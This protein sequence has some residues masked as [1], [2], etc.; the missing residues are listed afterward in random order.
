MELFVVLKALFETSSPKWIRRVD[1][2]VSPF[3]INRFLALDKR[4]V[5]TAQ[6][7]D[8]YTFTLSTSQWLYLAW[9]TL[10]RLENAPFF[11]Y[12]KKKTVVDDEPLL[13]AA[14]E[15]LGVKGNDKF[16]NHHL[17]RG[18]YDNK[19]YWLS[20]LGLPKKIWKNHGL[21][22]HKDRPHEEREIKKNNK[23]LEQWC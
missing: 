5:G 9:S 19:A 20:S 4:T 3:V 13:Q 8:K 16:D 17:A 10:P 21:D 14:V 1:S 7:L 12:P 18:L 23:G 22:Y 11:R 15:R 2:G 6:Y